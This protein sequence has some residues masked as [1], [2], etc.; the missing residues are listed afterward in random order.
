MVF[1]EAGILALEACV[2]VCVFKGISSAHS[3]WDTF[4]EAI[5]GVAGSFL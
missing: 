2:C 3:V 1:L 4:P 5:N